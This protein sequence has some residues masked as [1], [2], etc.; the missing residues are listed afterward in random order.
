VSFL[1][2]TIQTQIRCIVQ[3]PAWSGDECLLDAAGDRDPGRFV[4]EL[5]CWVT[6]YPSEVEARARL[7]STTIQQP[8]DLLELLGY[9]LG[10]SD[11]LA[12]PVL[13]D[14]TL[15]WRAAREASDG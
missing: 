1:T 11:G 4:V 12:I 7:M 14:E 6:L 2:V 15:A 8:K 10:R 3:G 9:D 13:V 5:G